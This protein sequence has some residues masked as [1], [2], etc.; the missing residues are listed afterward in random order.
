MPQSHLQG[1]LGPIPLSLS[2]VAEKDLTLAYDD[3]TLG[4]HTWPKENDCVGL[5]TKEAGHGLEADC[6]LFNVE[7]QQL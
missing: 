4:L 1:V 6:Q 3:A 5:R 2:P 7:A